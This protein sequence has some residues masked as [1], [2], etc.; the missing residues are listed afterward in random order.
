MFYNPF[1]ATLRSIVQDAVLWDCRTEAFAVSE[2]IDGFQQ[3]CFPLPVCAA[4]EVSAGG[5]KDLFVWKVAELK[6]AELCKLHA[7]NFIGMTT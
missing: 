4:E 7:Q 5:E 3:V 6:N 1:Y 2:E